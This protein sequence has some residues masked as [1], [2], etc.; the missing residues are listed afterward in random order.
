MEAQLQEKRKCNTDEEADRADSARM[1]QKLSF[2]LEHEANGSGLL[3]A[4]SDICSVAQMT[5]G[6]SEEAH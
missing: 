1:A 3:N 2:N 6:S 5:E 4:L